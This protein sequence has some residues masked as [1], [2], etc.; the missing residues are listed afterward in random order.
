[1]QQLGTNISPNVSLSK[2][3][4]CYIIFLQASQEVIVFFPFWYGDGKVDF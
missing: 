3:A 4:L 2:I 1:M